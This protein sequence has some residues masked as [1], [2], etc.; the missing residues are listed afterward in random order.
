VIKLI[1]LGNGCRTTTRS[2][3]IL[4]TVPLFR[5]RSDIA[6]PEEHVTNLDPRFSYSGLCAFLTVTPIL[7]TTLVNCLRDGFTDRGG[8]TALGRLEPIDRVRANGRSRRIS[9]IAVRPGEGL[10]SDHIRAL[11]FGGGNRSSCTTPAVR[12]TRRD[13]LSRVGISL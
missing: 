10:L 2:G 11:G 4:I 8:L 6:D 5:W 9:P 13:R 3:E 7:L 1:I 12:R